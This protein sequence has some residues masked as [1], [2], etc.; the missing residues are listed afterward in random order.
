MDKNAKSAKGIPKK[1]GI[2]GAGE[3]KI[4]RFRSG[5]I[6]IATIE[7]WHG[8][9]VVVYLPPTEKGDLWERKVLDAKLKQGH[10]L[11]C[12]DMDDDGDE[13]I[14]VGWRE[15]SEGRSYGVAIYDPV[16]E[17]WNAGRKSMVD[18][19][20]MACEDLTVADLNGDGFPEIIASGRASHNV[21]IYWNQGKEQ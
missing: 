9:Q 11:W 14:V 13:E 21:K 16:D 15:P 1:K 17:N 20:G 5:R 4:G 2:T 3:V 18:E 6:Y 19:G 7:P 8:N 12:A 10:A